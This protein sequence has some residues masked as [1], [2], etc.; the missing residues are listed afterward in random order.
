MI[1]R[2]LEI[3]FRELFSSAGHRWYG[4]FGLIELI[5]LGEI[6]FGPSLI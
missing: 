1:R 2:L 6:K 3:S 5:R 4:T